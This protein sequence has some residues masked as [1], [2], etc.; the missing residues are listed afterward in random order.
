MG[1]N[2]QIFFVDGPKPA[3]DEVIFSIFDRYEFN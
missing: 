3:H 1:F 2:A